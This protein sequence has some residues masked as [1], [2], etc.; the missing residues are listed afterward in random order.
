MYKVDTKA[1]RIRMIECGYTT[2]EKLAEA[3]GVNRNT[4]SDIVNG[5]SYPSGAVLQKLTWALNLEPEQA[6]R[7]FLC[8]VLASDESTE[9]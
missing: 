3:S 7:I 6:G 2:F 5:K 8:P 4:I 1:F 9:V